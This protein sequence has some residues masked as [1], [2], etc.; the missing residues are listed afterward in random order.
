MNPYFYKIKH[1]PSG[2][3]Y[4]GSQ[5]G[6]NSDPKKFWDSYMTSSKYIKQMISESG[7]NSFVIIKIVER[8][9]AREYE[10]RLLKRLYNFFGKEK[11]LEIMINRN[12]SPGILLTDEI[13]SKA[14]EKRKISNSISAKK[15]M[16]EGRHNFQKQ[17][18]GEMIHVKE[19]RSKR[20]K[21]NNYGSLRKITQELIDKLSEKSKGNTNV[22]GTK[23]WY[24]E[25]LKI[26]KRCKDC[27]GDGWVN[28]CPSNISEEGRQKIKNAASKPKSEKHRKKLSNAAKKRY[29]DGNHNF[30]R[31]KCNEEIRIQAN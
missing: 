20:M 28:K 18:S 16:S 12:I 8:A 19:S 31:E 2:R 30:I 22:R 25:E 3:Y 24:N 23:W 9:D 29:E 11:F 15:L 13:I 21:N 6:K 5:Y 4:V 14:N 26:K 7:K 1:I 17:K 27:P 10:C